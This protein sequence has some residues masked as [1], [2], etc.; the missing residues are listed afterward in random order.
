MLEQSHDDFYTPTRRN[1]RTIPNTTT[2]T[3][4]A[5]RGEIDL[6]SED[7]RFAFRQWGMSISFRLRNNQ[8]SQTQFPMGLPKENAPIWQPQHRKAQA[9]ARICGT[10]WRAVVAHCAIN[11]SLAA[12]T[13]L[14]S[15]DM[16][17]RLDCFDSSLLPDR[18]KA[19]E[20]SS[21]RFRNNF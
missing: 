14:G 4:M 21:W 1:S 11:L 10:P 15:T 16:I 18:V 3:A 12:T 20:Q 5:Q 7:G 8:I 6:N 9:G 19:F 17:Q 13:C 2:D